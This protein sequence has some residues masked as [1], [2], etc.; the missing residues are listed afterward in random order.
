M[1]IQMLEHPFEEATYLEHDE[2]VYCYI[3]GILNQNRHEP[4]VSVFDLLTY[5]HHYYFRESTLLCLAQWL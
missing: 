3:W 4:M 1:H 2:C 5:L